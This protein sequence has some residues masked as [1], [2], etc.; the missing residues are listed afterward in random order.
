MAREEDSSPETPA[1]RNLIQ[2]RELKEEVTKTL[3][4]IPYN[5]N[6]KVLHFLVGASS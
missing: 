5:T 2:S 6:T 4:T 3:N 1:D